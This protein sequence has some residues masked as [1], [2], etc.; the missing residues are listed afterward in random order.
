MEYTEMKYEP[1]GE[2]D[3]PTNIQMQAQMYAQAFRSAYNTGAKTTTPTSPSRPEQHRS[4]MTGI[5]RM[6]S[7]SECFAPNPSGAMSN[8]EH[9][10]SVVDKQFTTSCTFVLILY[11]KHTNNRRGF[12]TSLLPFVRHFYS[13]FGTCTAFSENTFS[14]QLLWNSTM[15]FDQPPRN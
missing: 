15:P 9:W 4:R 11:S 13:F 5:S 6:L 1:G 3:T 2:E 8:I 10:Q 12:G 7:L 14:V